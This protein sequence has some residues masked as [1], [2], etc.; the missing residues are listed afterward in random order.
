MNSNLLGYIVSIHV[1][2]AQNVPWILQ[3]LNTL[4]N[5]AQYER[6]YSDP[7]LEKLDETHSM[8]QVEYDTMDQT[9]TKY[10][11]YVINNNIRGYKTFVKCDPVKTEV[12]AD[13]VI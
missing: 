5:S 12:N 8:H 9:D 2:L 3:N 11:W 7:S 4:L 6:K 10:Y 1:Y 13:S